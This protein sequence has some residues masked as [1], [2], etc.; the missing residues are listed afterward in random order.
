MADIQPAAMANTKKITFFIVFDFYPFHRPR[1]IQILAK[2]HF[3]TDSQ[4]RTHTST[5]ALQ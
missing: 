1:R 3:I 4:Y 2:K 5:G